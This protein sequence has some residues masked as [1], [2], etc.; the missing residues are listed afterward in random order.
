MLDKPR[1]LQGKSLMPLFSDP[2]K[3]VKERI[4]SRWYSGLSV[5]TDSYMFTLWQ[6]DSGEEYAR[7][8]FD[9]TKDYQET[10]NVS[11]K[12]NYKQVVIDMMKW[13]KEGRSLEKKREK[14]R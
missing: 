13:I 6:N 1:Q 7:M 5:K 8:L 10:V 2:S 12:E 3:E 4:F 9:H 14:I 11:E